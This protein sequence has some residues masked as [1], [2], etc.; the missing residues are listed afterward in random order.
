MPTRSST[1]PVFHRPGVRPLLP[2]RA[3][4][5]LLPIALAAAAAAASASGH[6]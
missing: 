2:K 1:V 4:H 5:A 6:R 3:V